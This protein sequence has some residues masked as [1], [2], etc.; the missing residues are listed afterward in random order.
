[1]SC[2]GVRNITP[3]PEFKGPARGKRA[4]L[5]PFGR[6]DPPTGRPRAPPPAPKFTPPNLRAAM[7]AAPVAAPTKIVNEDDE[8]YAPDDAEKEEAALAEARRKKQEA[9]AAARDTDALRRD[10]TKRMGMLD[11]LLDKTAMYS[12]FVSSNIKMVDTKKKKKAAAD[13]EESEE[14]SGDEEEE[15]EEGEGAT[16][17]GKK[18]SAA[19]SPK[20]KV[21]AKKAK[22]KEKFDLNQ[23]DAQESA[24]ALRQDMPVGWEL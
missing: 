2:E 12:Q 22:K 13:E 8:E 21:R 14:E 15:E 24:D 16:R 5:P 11:S 17:S 1:M 18:R 19:A 4:P 10:A 23:L 7:E 3:P 9:E 20:K 6:P